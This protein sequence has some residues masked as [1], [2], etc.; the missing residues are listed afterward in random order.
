MG[1]ERL[2]E[3]AT[4]DLGLGDVGNPR[5][6]GHEKF[7]VERELGQE[8][9][10]L[11]PRAH[12]NMVSGAGHPGSTREVGGY[13]LAKLRQALDWQVV[14][15]ARADPKGL[16]NRGGNR[17]R[18]LAQ[19]ELVNCAPAPGEIGTELV[20]GQG[21]R[22]GAATDGAAELGGVG[23]RHFRKQTGTIE[24]AER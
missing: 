8:Q 13:R 21:G 9:Q 22:G 11:G 2:L 5:R 16:D 1:L 12:Q 15:L 19:P 14:L 4:E 18:G 7:G 10:F 6:G 24:L 23:S 17:E 20:D 3:E